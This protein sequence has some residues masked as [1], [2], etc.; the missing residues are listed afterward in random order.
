MLLAALAFSVGA[1]YEQKWS[2]FKRQTLEGSAYIHCHAM[3][4]IRP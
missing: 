1:P 4:A 2:K 3:A